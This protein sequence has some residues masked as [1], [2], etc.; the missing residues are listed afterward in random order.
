MIWH[1]E[2]QQQVIEESDIFTFVCFE[3]GKHIKRNSETGL[4]YKI[5]IHIVNSK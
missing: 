4:N 2:I 5:G 1:C 3:A